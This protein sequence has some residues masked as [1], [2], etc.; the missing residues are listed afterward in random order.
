MPKNL[1]SVIEFL[2]EH[3]RAFFALEPYA[4]E[5][6]HTTPSDT[7]S[8]SEVLISLLTGIR[9][10]D[11][12]K[13][14]DFEDG[15]DVKAANVWEAIDTPRFNG[16]A[17]AGRLSATSRK[18]ENL[19]AFAD[20]P[21][22]FFVLW[23][24]AGKGHRC[25]V[26]VVRTQHDT[27]FRNVVSEWYEKRMSGEIKSTN[28]QLHPP[29]NKND[30]VIRNSCGNLSYPLLFRADNTGEGYRVVTHDE[31]T[32]KRGMCTKAP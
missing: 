27:E 10:R 14:S 2:N 30:N 4:T 15:S 28:F 16:C 19:S 9:G 23:D 5:T 11:R 20:I 12:Q 25:R 13:G 17:P 29:R 1:T 31:D 3:H 18:E 22:L 32:L 26:W 8:A 21:Y 6:G 7:K 24:Y